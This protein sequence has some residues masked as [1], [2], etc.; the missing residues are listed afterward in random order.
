VREGHVL[1]VGVVV[2]VYLGQCDKHSYHWEVRLVLGSVNPAEITLGC[3]FYSRDE[4]LPVHK[5]VHSVVG[6]LDHFDTG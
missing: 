6:H 2:V 3:D 5:R 4:L 1:Q